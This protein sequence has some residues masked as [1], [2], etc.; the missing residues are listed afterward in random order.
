MAWK[1]IIAKNSK[2]SVLAGIIIAA[3][4]IA[5]VPLP[6]LRG[7][8]TPVFLTFFFIASGAYIFAILRLKRDCLSLKYIFGFGIIFRFI[9][10]FS[11]PTLSDDIYRYIW[12]GHLLN[13]GV[14][15][16]AFPVNAPLLDPLAN[17]LRSLV[18]H[19][20]MASPYLPASQL[21]F[22]IVE[23]IIPQSMLAFQVAAAFFDL[24]TGWFVL[25]ILRLLGLPRKN[26]LVYLWNPLV[27]I[28]FSHSAHVDALMICFMML[29][30]WFLVKESQQKKGGSLGSVIALSAATLT[31]FLPILLI[32]IFIWRWDWKRQMIFAAVLFVALGVFIPG[33]GL[34]LFGPLDGTGVFGALR[35]Y[36]QGWNYNSGIYHWLEVW[37][38][39]Y[40]TPGAVPVDLVGKTPI[41][42]AKAITTI[43]L[44]ITVL[45]TGWLAWRIQKSDQQNIH[46]QN[47]ALIRLSLLPLGAYLLLA[48]TIH[49]WYVT[50]II[51]FL[52][53]LIPKDAQSPNIKLFLWPWVYFSIV[54]T[55]SYLTYLNPD[56]FRETTWVRLLEYIPL[57]GLLGW[58]FIQSKKSKNTQSLIV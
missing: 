42:M 16:Y 14:N 13:S 21:V 52:P 46:D 45:L 31:K 26:V 17:S 29:A 5:L 58:A 40:A 11:M 25:D 30:F 9:L 1:N 49:P 55:L 7:S 51:P 22:A 54:V 27:I 24:L 19:N 57:Y 48:A 56:N 8:Y 41:Y 28:E 33:A 37:L 43:L 10:L 39:G 12:D 44:A 34:G 2:I 53:F 38:S 32:P 50:L 35:I 6:T 47:L 20:W 36:I 15:P 23:A 4:F 18:N 3:S